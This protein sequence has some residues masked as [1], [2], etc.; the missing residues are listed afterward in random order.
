VS[1]TSAICLKLNTSAKNV[2]ANKNRNDATIFQ[3]RTAVNARWGL[4]KMNDTTAFIG[5]YAQK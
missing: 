2:L 4:S 1:I 5:T 3:E